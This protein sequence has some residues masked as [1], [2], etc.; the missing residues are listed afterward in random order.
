MRQPVG[1]VAPYTKT[2]CIAALMKGVCE[3]DINTGHILKNFGNP[4]ANNVKTRFNDGKCDKQGRFWFGSM[5]LWC[6]SGMG[7]LYCL[8]PKI[9]CLLL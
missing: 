6:E 7:S 5:G 2:S 1:T 3:V 8:D 4:E 9:S